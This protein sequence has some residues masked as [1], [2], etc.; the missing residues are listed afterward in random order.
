MDENVHSNLRLVLRKNVIN[1]VLKLSNTCNTNFIFLSDQFYRVETNDA[2]TKDSDLTKEKRFWKKCDR[3]NEETFLKE[4]DSGD[5]LLFT[6]KTLSSKMTRKLTHSAY[7]H[8]AMILTFTDD[9]DIYILEATS[10]GV[11]VVSWSD[12]RRFK[13]RIYSKIV[14]RK[15]YSDRNDEF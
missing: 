15:L 12:M 4:A 1:G 6:G 3:I 10:D 2:K 13:D 7:D 8:V 9:D 11:H 5:I 14:W